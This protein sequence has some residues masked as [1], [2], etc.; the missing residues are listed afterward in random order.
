MKKIIIFGA[1]GN[2]GSYVLKYAKEYFDANKY[3]VIA[4]GRRETDFFSSMD[5]PYYS[6]D[7]SK[8]EDFDKLPKEDVYAV[9]FL[10]A[11]I[12]SYMEGYHPEKY[13]ESNILGAYN[14]LE[15]CRKV[16]A[17]R[18][19][20]STTVFDISLCAKDDVVLKPDLPYN[21]SY[22]GDHSV[23]VISKNTAIELIEHYH[24]EYDI[25]KFVFRFPTIYSYSPYHYYHPNGIKTIRPIYLMIDKA[26]KGEPIELWGDPNYAKD[27]VHVYD[28]A[29]MICKTVE[30]NLE[31][32]FYNVGTG[33]PVTLQEQIETIIKVFSPVEHPSEIIYRLDKKAGGGFLMDIENAKRE[34]GYEPQYDCLRLFEDYK[35]EMQVDRFKEL[36]ENLRC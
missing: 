31:K 13:I 19:L 32:G 3:E 34:L 12:P 9:V 4:T 22:K 28:C 14:V 17:D 7:I 33:R 21:F 1:T 36:R 35:A 6:V 20:Y 25:K 2:V 11:Q 18:I 15:Y 23:Y 5:I 8:S 10:A 24:Q 27:M 29:Q 16:K 26:M 30:A